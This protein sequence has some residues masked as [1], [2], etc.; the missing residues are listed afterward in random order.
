MTWNLLH[1]S[2]R[3]SICTL[4]REGPFLSRLPYLCTLQL[5]TRG[6]LELRNCLAWYHGISGEK[7]WWCIEFPLSLEIQCPFISNL[8]S[9][10]LRQ[11]I[12]WTPF[13]DPFYAAS[14]LDVTTDT[15]TLRLVLLIKWNR[16]REHALWLM[17]DA[18]GT[19]L[20]QMTLLFG[21]SMMSVSCR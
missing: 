20:D 9:L 15:I 4:P 2:I 19:K 13:M 16:L 11:E 17:S 3:T 10:R 14:H 7:R 8:S 12:R 18:A 6:D 21:R 1:L 5:P